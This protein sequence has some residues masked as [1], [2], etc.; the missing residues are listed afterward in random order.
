[1][2]TARSWTAGGQ[3]CSPFSGMGHSLQ[4]SS[5]RFTAWTGLRKVLFRSSGTESV[6][7]LRREQAQWTA[8]CH[9]QLSDPGLQPA[10]HPCPWDSPGKNPGAGCHALPPPGDLPHPGIEPASPALQTNSFPAEPSGKPGGHLKQPCLGEGK[11]ACLHCMQTWE[12]VGFT[13]G[14][15]PEAWAL[16]C[17]YLG[18]GETA[19]ER[20]VTESKLCFK[21]VNM[22]SMIKI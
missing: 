21:K 11:E 2:L 17:R 13:A 22:P 3:R 7:L 4:V 15:K 16:F 1:M 6:N 14:A 20:D 19:L 5:A 18:A 12:W 9:V 10:R 8:A